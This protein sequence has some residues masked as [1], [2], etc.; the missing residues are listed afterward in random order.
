MWNSLSQALLGPH[1]SAQRVIRPRNC[2]LFLLTLVLP[3]TTEFIEWSVY[4]KGFLSSRRLDVAKQ[5]LYPMHLKQR[6]M[7]SWLRHT[8]FHISA[9]KYLKL[10]NEIKG[11]VGTRILNWT[12]LALIRTSFVKKLQATAYQP[13]NVT[14]QPGGDTRRVIH[15]WHLYC[16]TK[17]EV[18][19]LFASHQTEN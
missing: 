7:L 10:Y 11:N 4:R 15:V 8:M 2:F 14:H 19:I 9:I 6:L 3:W 16:S 1:C 17:L 12:S 18:T 5:T 13:S